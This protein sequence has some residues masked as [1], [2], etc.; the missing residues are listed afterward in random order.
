VGD[1][2]APHVVG[3]GSAGVGFGDGAAFGFVVEVPA[4]FISAFFEGV[5]GDVFLAGFVI[6]VEM[7]GAVG[8]H[9]GAAEAHV[10][11]AA[12]DLARTTVGGVERSEADA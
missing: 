4:G 5:E 11:D 1:A 7:R 6:I 3:E 2:I 10:E 8:E 12:F 9:E